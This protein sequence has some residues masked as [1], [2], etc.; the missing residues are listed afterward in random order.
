MAPAVETTQKSAHDQADP[1]ADNDVEVDIL[2][3]DSAVYYVEES[4]QALALDV[5]RL[6]EFKDRIQV[7]YYTEDG[8]GIAG[9]RYEAASGTLIF[10]PGELVKTIKVPII[11]TD[12]WATTLEFKVR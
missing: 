5:V 6:G 1:P 7:S 10:E 2:Q 12:D 3:F 11:D 4:E 8:S 9:V